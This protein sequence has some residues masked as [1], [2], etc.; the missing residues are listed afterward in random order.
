MN[1]GAMSEEKFMNS[2]LF[3][4]L[5]LI[6][7]AAA[8]WLYWIVISKLIPISQVG[9][10][11]A[12]YSLV[13]LTATLTGLGLEYPLLKKTSINGSKVIG[14]ALIIEMILT[15]GAI[16]FVIYALSGIHTGEL[17][18]V[19]VISIIMLISST[20][21]FVGRFT[22]LGNSASKTVLVIDSIGTILK[23]VTAFILVVFGFGVLGVLSSFMLYAVVTASISITLVNKKFGFNIGKVKYIKDTFRDGVVNLPS[24]FSRTL[25][26]SL[27][28]VLL[29]FFGIASSEIGNFYIALMISIFAGGLI[30]STA[31][32]VI[33]AS[34][35]SQT[36]LSAD[37]I[38]I[39]LSLTAP[40]MA[41]LIESPKFI[42][43][44][45]G[46]EYLTGE[47]SLLI[48]AIGI[49]PFAITTNTVSRL[50]YI[51]DSR[52][53]LVI[54]SLQMV[55]FLLSFV[56]LVPHFK[57]VGAAFSILLAYTASCILSLIWSDKILL[58]YI[59]NI[60]I[61]VITACAISKI[62]SWF[63]PAGDIGAS[64]TLLSSM[65]ITL[66]IVFASKTMLIKEV[67][68]I[69]KTVIRSTS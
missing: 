35:R 2:S 62:F 18:G 65:I 53:L 28:V 48:L 59:A 13:F 46:K 26:I 17:Q 37:S 40:I 15:L 14:S 11:T 5:D 8:S 16:P 52:R 41:A 43:S 10:S 51:G 57:G 25:I 63:L 22:L 29:A 38:R 19:I 58:R 47:L 64:I 7:I 55:V 56:V 49:L 23:F 36:D 61:A 42:L 30:S 34:A 31:Y 60:V 1:S 6:V 12:L 33:P 67:T 44:L 20:I 4:F 50:N 27:S 9:Q 39:G 69:L 32:M 45:I 66:A 21:A 3:L 68:I 54:G 24:V